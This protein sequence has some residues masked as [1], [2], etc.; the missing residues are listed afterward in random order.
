MTES[1]K[2][3]K[4]LGK[5]GEAKARRY[6]FFKGWKILESNYRTPFGEIDII[7]RKGDVIAFIEVKTRLSDVFG[8]PSEAVD[9]MRKQRY[10][11]GANYFLMNKNVDLTVRFDIIEVFRG[12]LNHIENA[13][14]S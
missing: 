6:L 14:Y 11:M 2:H 1:G 9:G 12:Q 8:L 7:A 4:D 13:F 3:N 5:K 10:I